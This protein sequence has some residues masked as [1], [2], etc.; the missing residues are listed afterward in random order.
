M[1]A[2]RAACFEGASA[3]SSE[4]LLS[5]G[6]LSSLEASRSSNSARASEN[7]GRSTH[8]PFKMYIE[9]PHE[10]FVPLVGSPLELAL[11]QPTAAASAPIATL[12]ACTLT[13]RSPGCTPPAR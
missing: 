5:L 1:S 3:P 12:E 9:A 8:S 10:T 7:G 11:L 4:G 13:A 6:A 2:S